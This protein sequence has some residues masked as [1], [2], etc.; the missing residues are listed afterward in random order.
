MVGDGW[1]K[2]GNF[3][4]TKQSLQKQKVT[5]NFPLLSLHEKCSYLEFFWS[6]F[7]R[8]RTEYG[9]SLSNSPYTV[10]LRK[11]I[12]HKN[13][14]QGQ[15]Y[16]VYLPKMFPMKYSL[17]LSR[18]YSFNFFKGCLPQILLCPILNT[19]SQIL[20]TQSSKTFYK[21]FCVDRYWM[22]LLKILM[23]QIYLFLL[24]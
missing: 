9:D 6:V 17:C 8:I 5:T 7:S 15:F 11:N 16:A 2:K 10:K 14:E 20:L 13:F 22:L 4:V 1:V 23:F 19:L 24:H 18:P 21:Y 12:D 3:S